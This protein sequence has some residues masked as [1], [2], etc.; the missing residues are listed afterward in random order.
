MRQGLVLLAC[1]LIAMS[2]A[3]ASNFATPERERPRIHALYAL[4]VKYRFGGN[5]HEE[6]FDC[7][8]LV[9]HV[10]GRAWGIALPRSVEEQRN[11]GQPVRGLKELAPGD[12]VFYNTRNRPYSHVGIYVGHGF[13]VHAP[14]PGAQVRMESVQT[15]YWR[16]RFNGA[17]RLD[18]PTF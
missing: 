17:R 18:P 9:T 5:S 2:D 13:F 14:R 11:V 16:E 6:G 3:A 7:S 1:G 10:Y 8:G 15:P 12:L 4:G